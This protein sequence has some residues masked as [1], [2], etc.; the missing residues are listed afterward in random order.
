M[1]RIN[2]IQ[3]S[4][5]PGL[6]QGRA[7]NF[8]SNQNFQGGL[9]SISKGSQKILLNGVETELDKGLGLRGKFYQWL[10]DTKGELQV[11]VINAI[12]TT[13]LAPLMI[14]CNPFAKNKTKEDKEYLALRQPVSATISL[15]GGLLMTNLI[16]HFMDTMYN[17]GYAESIDL[18]LQPNKSYTR[19]YFNKAYKEAKKNG[20][21]K[22][23]LTKY[24][25]EVKENIKTN[26]FKNGHPSKQYVKACFKTGY[27]DKIKNE[28]LEL[29]TNILTEEDIN[30]I[31]LDASKNI[32]LEGKNLQEGHLVK[33]PN[34][35]SQEELTSY[36]SKNN[37]HNRKF[38][39]F[40]AERFKFEFFNE[41]DG[42]HT[43]EIKP[44]IVKTKLSDVKA[45][46]FLIETGLIEEGKIEENELTKTLSRLQ[47]EKL[48]PIAENELYSIPGIFQSDG[49]MKLLELDGK[50]SSRISEYKVGEEIGYEKT[51]SLS[52]LFHRLNIKS[53]N[54]ELQK[55][56]DM[57]MSDALLY[58]H[59]KLKGKLVGYNDKADLKSITKNL[60]K[61]TAKRIDKNAESHK[62]FVGIFFNL[63][64]T[65][66][67]CTILNWAYPRFV[68]TFFPHLVKKE[69][70]AKQVEA[71]KQEGG[72]K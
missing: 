54:G 49:A 25:S 66:V 9:D 6:S 8:A 67:T 60:L 39:D 14:V 22:E 53:D 52:H 58:L 71:Q 28:R 21:E 43:G 72:N 12:F 27:L 19:R 26:A 4:Y 62:F 45:L 48:K 50:V 32:V 57:K 7:K 20:K 38:G 42:T 55:L 16:N 29:F 46:D 23:F 44:E 61:N 68:E 17:E 34:I 15:S 69:N 51:I 35:N 40:L 41:K 11:Q 30:K 59:D 64:T 13:T 65:A 2:Q 70:P 56:A 31:K 47:Q 33:V 18:R 24:D 37:F 3:A 10:A 63:F 36:L 1:S 5:Q